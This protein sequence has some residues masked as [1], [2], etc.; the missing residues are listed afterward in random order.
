MLVE[1]M[2]S[3]LFTIPHDRIVLVGGETCQFGENVEL[4]ADFGG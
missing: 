1:Q 2:T 3:H 4:A